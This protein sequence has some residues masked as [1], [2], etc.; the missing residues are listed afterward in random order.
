MI[1]ITLP[2]PNKWLN[3]NNNHRMANYRAKQEA[4]EYAYYMT[5]SHILSTEYRPPE[6]MTITYTFC[7]PDK[8]KRD[9]DNFIAAMKASRDGVAKALGV[10]DTCFVTQPVEWGDVVRGGRVTLR[11]E[12]LD[13]ESKNTG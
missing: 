5:L 13:G 12:V 6:Q 7:P 1:E 2:W 4:K 3:P 11:L 8:R 9:D 10:D